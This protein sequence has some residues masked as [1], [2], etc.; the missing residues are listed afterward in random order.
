MESTFSSISLGLID[1]S[2]GSLTIT[3]LEAKDIKIVD[4][5]I[6]KINSGA[7][8]VSISEGLFSNIK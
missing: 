4:Y 3:T 8:E 2:I 1:L 7:G 5:S 6:I